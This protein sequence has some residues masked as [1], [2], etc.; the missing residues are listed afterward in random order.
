M[1]LS[2]N[3]GFGRGIYTEKYSIR[4]IKHKDEYDVI[5]FVVHKLDMLLYVIALLS[6]DQCLKTLR[7]HY[8]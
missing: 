4:T 3:L 2:N 1:L 8:C 7:L 6:S 5:Y